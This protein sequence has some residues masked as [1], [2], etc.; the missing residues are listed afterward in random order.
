MISAA[1]V[2]RIPASAFP[3]KVNRMQVGLVDKSHRNSQYVRNADHKSCKWAWHGGEIRR[4]VNLGERRNILVVTF[5]VVLVLGLEAISIHKKVSAEKLFGRWLRTHL[6]AHPD[7]LEPAA[8]SKDV[9]H[10]EQKSK[11]KALHKLKVGEKVRSSAKHPVLSLGYDG[12]M[13]S[14]L[15]DKTGSFMRTRSNHVLEKLPVPSASVGC[16]KL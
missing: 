3:C 7:S 13:H 6:P 5:V 4:C 9:F 14:G 10:F 2:S 16:L 11:G 1:I 8:P 12:D 15:Y